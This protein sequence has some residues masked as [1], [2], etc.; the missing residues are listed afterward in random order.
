[1]AALALGG[2]VAAVYRKVKEFLDAGSI[3]LFFSADFPEF[4]DSG[5][6]FVAVHYI[7]DGKM[8][9]LAIPYDPKTGEQKPIITE[10]EFIGL[11]KEQFESVTGLSFE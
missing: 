2:D 11:L 1:M 5:S 10:G 4:S 6:D 9:I 7:A 8:Q 3:K